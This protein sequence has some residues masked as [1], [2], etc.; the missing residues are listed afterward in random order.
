MKEYRKKPVIVKAVRLNVLGEHKMDLPEGVKG[1]PSGGADNWAYMGCRFYV[2]TIHGQLTEVQDGDWIVQEPDG[3]HYYPVKHDI[4]MDT[5]DP[6]DEEI[7][8]INE[9]N[10]LPKPTE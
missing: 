4:F 9:F 10:L 5:Y 2:E 3:E 1:C 7:T 8:E 6:V